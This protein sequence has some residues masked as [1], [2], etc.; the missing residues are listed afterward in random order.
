ML[1]MLRSFKKIKTFPG[2]VHPACSKGLTE[3]KATEIAPL[4]KRVGVPLLQ[5]I[6][7]PAK[8]LVKTGDIVLK[9][10]PIGEPDGFVS[11]WAHSPIS[12]KVT[13]VQ[14][15]VNPVY[16]ECETVFI[17]SDGND[18]EYEKLK[19]DSKDKDINRNDIIEL[20]KQAGIVGL[21]GA[22]FPTH[23]KIISTEKHEVHTLLVNGVECEPYLTC[24]Y[25][26]MLE[27]TEQIIVG[28]ELLDKALRPKKIYIAIEDNKKKAVEAMRSVLAKRNN[29]RLNSKTS[30]VTLKTKYPQGGEKQIIKSILNREVPPEKLPFAVGCIAQNVGT[31]KA[32]FDAVY[33]RKP[34]IER[35]ITLT[36]SC[37]KKQ[38]NYL[39]RI[40][41]ML[42]DLVEGCCGGFVKEPAKVILGGPMMGITQ[43]TMDVPIMKGVSGVV[44]LSKEEAECTEETACIKCGKCVDVCPVNLL[45]AYIA[46]SA[47]KN[48]AKELRGLNV[49]DCIECGSCSFECPARIPLV[50]YI[51]LAKEKVRNFC[52]T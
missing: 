50:Q 37:L 22:A 3:G 20:I 47:K 1:D 39:V 7:R 10:Q 49:F 14:K 17:E 26:L 42:S 5:S 9:G 8:S 16:N 11:T 2:G 38:G 12:G 33:S 43:F 24:D 52:D 27:K 34:L 15:A 35:S 28:V 25:R 48:D 40:G 29:A 19:I 46:R 4:P 36:G 6:G 31:L 30:V 45:P 41:S 32:V 23:V 13:G 18:N 51:K 44:F 21:G